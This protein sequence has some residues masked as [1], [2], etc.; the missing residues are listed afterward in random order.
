MRQPEFWRHDG[1]VAKILTPLGWAFHGAGRIRRWAARPYCA[2]IPVIC[3]GNLVAGGAGKT[4]VAMAIADMLLAARRKPHFLTR[5][6]GG[7][8]AGPVRVDRS[9]HDAGAVGD[10]AL[11]LADM[12]PCWVAR[13]RAD[14]AR[15]AVDAGAEIIVMDDGFQNPQPAKDLSLIVIDGGVGFGNRRVI[16]AGPLRENLAAGIRRADAAILIGLDTSDAEDA[17]GGR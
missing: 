11:L 16:P 6:F 2:P 17:L 1:A 14:G 3:V 13:D 8:L 9:G 10:E 5:G 7:G 4:P 15:A 12:A